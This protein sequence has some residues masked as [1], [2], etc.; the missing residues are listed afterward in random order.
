MMSVVFDLT[1]A[2]SE[3]LDSVIFMEKS[4]AYAAFKEEIEKIL[5]DFNK[6]SKFGQNVDIDVKNLVESSSDAV[7]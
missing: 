2:G 6:N 3:I 1:V 4:P 7:K 5:A